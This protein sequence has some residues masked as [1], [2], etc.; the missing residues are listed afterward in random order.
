MTVIMMHEDISA[1]LDVCLNIHVGLLTN[2]QK[3]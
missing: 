3:K 2:C 1:I